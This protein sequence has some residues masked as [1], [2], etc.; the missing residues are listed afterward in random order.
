MKSLLFSLG[1]CVLATNA[2]A[3]STVSPEVLEEK[4]YA[5]SSNQCYSLSKTEL[6]PKTLSLCISKEGVAHLRFYKTITPLSKI[7]EEKAEELLGGKTLDGAITSTLFAWNG[8]KSEK[9]TVIGKI[10]NG[11]LQSYKLIGNGIKQSD[12]QEVKGEGL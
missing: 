4:T 1:L 9:F 5:D 2:N 10:E 8:K 12:F 3:S 6:G 7:T 11:F